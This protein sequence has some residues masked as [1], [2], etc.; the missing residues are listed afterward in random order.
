MAVLP[1]DADQDIG[2]FRLRL[3]DFQIALQGFLGLELI[4]VSVTLLQLISVSVAYLQFNFRGFGA[5]AA[6]GKKH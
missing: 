2:I 3:L 6:T 4:R 5:C 1:R